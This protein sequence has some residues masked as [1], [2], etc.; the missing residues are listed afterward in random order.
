MTAHKTNA[1]RR[2]RDRFSLSSSSSHHFRGSSSV[3]VRDDEFDLVLKGRTTTNRLM[4]KTPFNFSHPTNNNPHDPSAW[5]ISLLFWFRPMQ[6]A[7]FYNDGDY[8]PVS[9][10]QSMIF[11]PKFPIEI[12]HNKIWKDQIIFGNQVLSLFLSLSLHTQGRH[13]QRLI[14][15]RGES[16]TSNTHAHTH[17]QT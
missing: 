6:M 4:Q 15:E 14:E 17:T 5:T 16:K 11:S 7:R 3:R 9:A 2:T 10:L 12:F 1:T 13:I 8:L